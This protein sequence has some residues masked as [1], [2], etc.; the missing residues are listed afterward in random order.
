M[1]YFLA[2]FCF[3]NQSEIGINTLIISSTRTKT[4]YSNVFS[5]ASLDPSRVSFR[6]KNPKISLIVSTFDESY[7]NVN[8]TSFPRMLGLPTL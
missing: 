6:I 8:L 7:M 3:I 1:I 4:L 5:L 2:K